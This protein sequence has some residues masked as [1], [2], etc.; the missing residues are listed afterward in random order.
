MQLQPD[1]KA[2]WAEGLTTNLQAETLFVQGLTHFQ[3]GSIAVLA[4]EQESALK[5]AIRPFNMAVD[6]D[7]GYA[8]AWAALGEAYLRLF[9]LNEDTQL[10]EPAEI[11][12]D[13][14][15][16]HRQDPS[17]RVDLA[18]H[19]AGGEGTV[20]GGGAGLPARDRNQP[21]RSR[22]LQGAWRS[23]SAGQPVGQSRASVPEGP[24][25]RAKRVGEP[26]PHGRP[27]VSA[28]GGLP[29]PRASSRPA[30]R[31]LPRTPGCGR[32]SGASTEDEPMKT[33]RPSTR[34]RPR[35]ANDPDTRMRC[36]TWA[37]FCSGGAATPKRRTMFGRAADLSPAMPDLWR[38]LGIRAVF[39]HR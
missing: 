1:Q 8:A 20:G 10:L 30:S 5:E 35:D 33:R 3:Q 39:R 11:G 14:G 28:R 31:S 24:R 23:V 36:R 6:N 37:I 32:I 9:R 22:R 21:G 18:G 29:R 15:A 13:E 16:R 7:P 27:A 26:Q 25:T 38:N 34:S 4:Y 17:L 12:V 19:A 2:L